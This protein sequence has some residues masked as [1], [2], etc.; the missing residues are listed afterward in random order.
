MNNLPEVNPGDHLVNATNLEV[1]GYVQFFQ[2]T[3]F[4]ENNN[5]IVLHLTP[6]QDIRWGNIDW[7]GFPLTL[8][9]DFDD[10]SGE[11]SK[12]KLTFGNPEGVFSQYAHKKYLDSAEVVRYRV[13]SSHVAANLNSFLKR[14]WRVSKVLSLSKDIVTVELRGALD[15]Q[16][17]RI[18]ARVF[19]PPEYPQVSLG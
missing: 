6:R 7:E 5:P 14:T 9:G 16:Q 15:G 8:V 10:S 17:F 3:L 2:I 11:Q 12:P 19:S 1:D 4:D 13:L 18:P